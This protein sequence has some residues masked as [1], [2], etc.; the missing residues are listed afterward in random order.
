MAARATK[1]ERWEFVQRFLTH[2]KESETATTYRA[3]E[4]AAALCMRHGATY[5][6]LQEI[7]CSV[8]LDD[9]EQR[10]HDKQEADIERRL[11]EVCK[12]YGVVP[13]FQGDPRGYTIKLIM[14]DGFSTD[15]GRVGLGVPT[16]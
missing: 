1:Q 12:P 15:W 14:P 2:T 7:A 8:Q 3:R 10:R 11:T 6:R 16:S 5:A 13:D 9:R 4:H